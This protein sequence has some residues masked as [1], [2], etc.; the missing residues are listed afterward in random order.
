MGDATRSSAQGT[1]DDIDDFDELD[2]DPDLLEP[3]SHGWRTRTAIEMVISGALGLLASFVLSIDA[4][5]LAADPKADLGCNV[6]AVLNCGT[7]A[8]SPQASLFGFPNAFLGIAAEAVVI[9]VA[10][11]IL[12]RVVLP[13]FFFMGSN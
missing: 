3:P 13:V 2:P 7:V 1:D 11:E 5:K 9:T 10:V 4:I 12:G 8:L 6:N